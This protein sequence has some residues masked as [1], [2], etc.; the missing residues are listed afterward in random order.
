[1]RK[2]TFNETFIIG[3]TVYSFFTLMIDRNFMYETV[4]NNP[5]SMYASYL[6]LMGSQLNIAIV[7]L[8]LAGITMSGLF[9]HNYNIRIIVSLLGLV[10]FTI[11]AA[12]FVFSYPN[13]GLGIS[14][15]VI[16]TMIANINHLIDE[17]QEARKRNIICDNYHNDKGGEKD[18]N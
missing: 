9:V 8:L 4:A 10:Y 17:Q 14:A 5:D 11:I 18:E 2:P 6:G 16:T 1:M 3:F 15:L 7:S 13:F 12:S